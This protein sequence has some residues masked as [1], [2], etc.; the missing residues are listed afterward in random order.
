MKK[1]Y[2]LAQIIADELE[3]EF[4]SLEDTCTTANAVLRDILKL[5]GHHN[6]LVRIE[7]TVTIDGDEFDHEW[8]EY[9]GE[10]IDIT[11]A[12]FATGEAEE[13][14]REGENADWPHLSA[15]EMEEIE[16]IKR[17]VLDTILET[18]ISEYV[19]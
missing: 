14:R 16:T 9:D 12:Q 13:Y 17:G 19:D 5:V 11:A 18:S 6:R 1:I 15:T 4:G 10:V 2:Q 8:A 3:G 7:G